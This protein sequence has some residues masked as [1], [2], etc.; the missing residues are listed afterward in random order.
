[1]SFCLWGVFRFL[2]TAITSVEGTSHSFFFFLRRRHLTACVVVIVICNVLTHSWIPSLSVACLKTSV[3]PPC[4]LCLVDRALTESG[5]C[6]D[7]WNVWCS[8]AHYTPESRRGTRSS[9]R[10]NSLSSSL[11]VRSELTVLHLAELDLGFPVV[12][13]ADGP[14]RALHTL[15]SVVLV[16]KTPVISSAH[17]E[18]T[19]S[20]VPRAASRP[21][22]TVHATIDT[23]NALHRCPHSSVT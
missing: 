3:L 21:H 23:C 13:R 2:V 20:T 22:H 17:R 5:T 12:V 10:Q 16:G 9:I 14:G 1:M 6:C 15:L 18:V 8:S 11:P 19:T 7:V 4:F